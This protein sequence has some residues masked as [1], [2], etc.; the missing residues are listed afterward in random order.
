MA[1]MDLGRWVLVLGCLALGASLGWAFLS[2]A[3]KTVV[4]EEEAQSLRA[5][6]GRLREAQ[7]SLE[8][9]LAAAERPLEAALRLAST[10]ESE[11]H[12][13]LISDPRLAGDVAAARGLLER[14][15]ASLEVEIEEAERPLAGVT[16]S[17]APPPPAAVEVPRE[18]ETER[19]DT[20]HLE[21]YRAAIALV[22]TAGGRMATGV[23][24]GTHD[25][26]VYILTVGDAVPPGARVTCL[27][28]L[29]GSGEE[30]FLPVACD[31]VHREKR[32]ELLLLEGAIPRSSIFAAVSEQQF[33]ESAARKGETV[34]SMGAHAVGAT[35]FTGSV[36]EGIVSTAKEWNDGRELLLTTLPA[37]EGSP[38]S[39]VTYADGR[40]AGILWHG[41]RGLDRATVVLPAAAVKPL[42]ERWRR[43][44]LSTSFGASFKDSGASG[45]DYA[46]EAWIDLGAPLDADA[47]VFAGPDDL[48]LI[49]DRQGGKLSAF[50]SGSAA[51]VWNLP[52]GSW[53]SFAYR[54]WQQQG[55]LSSAKART[56]VAVNLRSGK[57]VA[58]FSKELHGAFSKA[59]AAFPLGGSHVLALPRGLA[60]AS[61]ESGRTFPLWGVQVTLMAQMDDLL[62]LSTPEGDVGWL[63]R[64]EFLAILTRIDALLIE[65]AKIEA[66]SMHRVKKQE[67]MN[68]RWDQIRELTNQLGRGVKLFETR[69]EFRRDTGRPGAGF[70]HVP[71]SYLHLAGRDVW[72]IGPDQVSRLGHLEP[73]WHSAA[74]EGWFAARYSASAQ[75]CA[76]ASPDGRYAV[77]GTH[78]YELKGLDAVAELPF[79]TGPAG[80][81]SSGRKLYAYD[82]ELRRL[83]FLALD[84]VLRAGGGAAMKE[85]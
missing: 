48:V 52:R 66:D 51:P 44:T 10:V 29:Q 45:G 25:E 64:K 35:A 4:L 49:W 2:R 12:S 84:E 71:G 1:M 81:T 65:I 22:L 73:L 23:I 27:L 58:Q 32:S 17:N 67:E 75:P 47:E 61:L 83:V 14:Q 80:F 9:D 54:P 76:M 56:T 68:R 53:S 13:V 77:T 62:T 34:Y 70:C 69:G 60:I 63:T 59:W 6:L 74:H 8:R 43:Q 41:A 78:I 26:K 11:V 21:G 50:R 28:R 42:L 19:A 18:L 31:V 40:L 38:G 82:R 24:I 37:N 72:Q 33:Q 3:P 36:F 15:I 5:E 7:R 20:V 57:V 39:L 46:C 16:T 79:P 30:K 85:R 55:F